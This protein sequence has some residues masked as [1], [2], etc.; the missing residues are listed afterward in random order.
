MPVLR[1]DAQDLTVPWCL[2]RVA[3]SAVMCL[4]SC[5]CCCCCWQPLV[6]TVVACLPAPLQLQA[7]KL[8][9]KGMHC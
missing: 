3:G 8:V 4:S 1:V 5:A 2:L 6:A 9:K 7:L